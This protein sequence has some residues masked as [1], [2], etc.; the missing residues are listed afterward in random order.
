MMQG[1]TLKYSILF[2]IAIQCVSTFEILIAERINGREQNIQHLGWNVNK[3]CQIPLFQTRYVTVRVHSNDLHRHGNNRD[4]NVV[5][6]KFQI[7]SAVPNVVAIEKELIIP[8]GGADIH[9]RK[10]ILVEDLFIC[11]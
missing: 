8:T 10:L 4:G 7:K 9:D 5:G 3:S 1:Q 11:K 2:L 6:F